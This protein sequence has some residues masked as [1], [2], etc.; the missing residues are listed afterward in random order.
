MPLVIETR[1]PPDI[2]AA[3]LYAVLRLRVD[4]FVVEQR[5]PYPDLD[6]RD[7]L[8]DTV[9]VWAR[10]DD[11]LAGCL[12][13]L[14]HGT[15]TPAIGR[16]VTAPVA[17]GRGVAAT[18]MDHALTICGPD[19]TIEV[20]AQAHLEHWYGRFGFERAA[21]DHDEDGIPHVRMLRRPTA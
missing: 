17:R 10:E 4:V 21:P 15:G 13:V 2:S 20:D 7:L 16:V 9:H 8:A 1:T 12:R 14:R 6:G 5:C 19:A 3:D 11:V 18:L